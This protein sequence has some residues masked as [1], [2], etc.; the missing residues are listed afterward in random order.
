MVQPDGKIV[1]AGGDTPFDGPGHFA[2]A[3]YNP[4]GSLDR[5]FSRDG[6]RLVG[7]GGNTVASGVALQPD[8]GIVLAGHTNPLDRDTADFALARLRPNGTLSGKAVTSLG[9][10]D[11]A[12][13]VAVQPDGRIVAA[14]ST[15]PLGD[16]D[17]PGT[18]NLALA[19]YSG[20]N[21]D[22]PKARLV[23]RRRQRLGAVLRRGVVLR[24]RTAGLVRG[25]ARLVGGTRTL[26]RSR[27]RIYRR[28]S[29][30]IR[31]RLTR[32]AKRRLRRRGGGRLLLRVR[33]VNAE[34]TSRIAE[35]ARPDPLKRGVPATFARVVHKPPLL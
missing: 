16:N 6:E 31:V 27:P 15:G 26:R 30:R 18:D 23:V 34:G 2:V 3:R 1:A 32:A 25:S 10:G 14:G 12:G 19:R 5:S 29:T 11:G 13:A 17:F 20:L 35:G 7:F 9:R 24:L 28:G 4:N 22:R 33:V 21:I 8:G